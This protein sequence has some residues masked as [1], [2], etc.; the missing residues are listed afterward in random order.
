MENILS[1]EIESPV[2]LE[3]YRE[4]L[5]DRIASR[6]LKLPV[7][8]EVAL[9]VMDMMR[10]PDVDMG[11]L[12]DLIHGDPSLAGHVLLASNS[13]LYG[14]S[15]EIKTLRD[16]ITRLGANILGEI[17][18]SISIKG[19]VFYVP[20]YDEVIQQLWKHAQ[21]S[22]QIAKNVAYELSLIEDTM[23]LCGLLHTI[24]K[25]VILH[26]IGELQKELKLPLSLETAETLLEEFHPEVGKQLTE[27]WQMPE[28]VS[29]SCANYL[30]YQNAPILQREVSA[31][32]LSGMLSKSVLGKDKIEIESLKQDPVFNTLGIDTQEA[33]RLY[34]ISSRVVNLLI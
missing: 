17:V 27:F 10:Q 13:A 16:A 8:P 19:E 5:R 21:A 11:K 20:G 31:T 7:L 23:Y 2:V 4:A 6:K 3:A 24:G 1:P 28:Q 22:G 33:E 32:Y 12:S 15:R 9:K 29:V 30:S 25:P 26:A 18:L 14:A 34:E